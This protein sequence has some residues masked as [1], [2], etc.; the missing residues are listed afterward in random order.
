VVPPGPFQIGGLLLSNQE[1]RGGGIPGI[2]YP[3]PIILLV[4]ESVVSRLLDHNWWPAVPGVQ[5]PDKTPAISPLA[6][7]NMSESLVAVAW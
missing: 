2:G 3:A 5:D 4:V 1:R 7:A 6:K